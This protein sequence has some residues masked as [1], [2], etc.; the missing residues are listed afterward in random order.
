MRKRR[1]TVAS[2]LR[3]STKDITILG[4]QPKILSVYLTVVHPRRCLINT[5]GYP[6]FEGYSDGNPRLIT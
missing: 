3:Q 2:E 1:N 4:Y 6:P 5:D